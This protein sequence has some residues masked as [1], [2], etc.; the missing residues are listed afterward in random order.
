VVFFARK[1]SQRGFTIAELLMVIAVIGVLVAAASPSFMQWM[2]DKRVTDAAMNI[3]DLY[4]MARARAMGRGAAVTVRWDANAATPTA[5]NPA[6]HFSMREAIAG[7]LDP[8]NAQRPLSSC[9]TPTF[10]DNDTMSRFIQ[11]FDERRKRYAP[12]L[13]SFIYGQG[14]TPAYADICFTPRGRVFIRT[15]PGGAFEP[16]NGV[17]RVEILNQDDGMRRQIIVPPTGN[18]RVVTRVL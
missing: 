6:G 15:T 5:A 17:P 14:N 4:R 3:A 16:L 12:A 7:P 8:F 13:A 10:A 2:K 11:G 1:S 9:R 18:A